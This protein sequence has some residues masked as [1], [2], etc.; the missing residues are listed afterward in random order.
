MLGHWVGIWPSKSGG[1][2]HKHKTLGQSKR[3]PFNGIGPSNAWFLM[4]NLHRRTR[5]GARFEL[6]NCSERVQTSNFTSASL[7]VVGNAVHTAD[8]RYMRDK[9]VIQSSRVWRRELGI[10]PTGVDTTKFQTAIQ[11]PSASGADSHNSAREHC[12]MHANHSL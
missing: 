2:I 10:R 9:T 6:A 8:W 12:A 1:Y 3:V 5:R 4:P 11:L 7:R